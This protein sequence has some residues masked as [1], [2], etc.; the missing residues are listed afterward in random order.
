MKKPE[1]CPF[2]DGYDIVVEEKVD[3]GDPPHYYVRCKKCG[4]RGPVSYD[5]EEG[6]VANWNLR[7]P[8]LERNLTEE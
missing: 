3:Y 6:A 8:E 1:Q 2:C 7:L 4:A 5:G